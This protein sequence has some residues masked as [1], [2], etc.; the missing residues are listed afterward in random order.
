MEGVDYSGDRPSGLCLYSHGKRFVGRYF[1]PGGTWKH[2]T[3]AEVRAILAS[4]MAIFAL[5]EGD[6]GDALTGFQTG[7]Q[8][9]TQAR[10]HIVRCG[11]PSTLPI[12][13]AVDFDAQPHQFAAIRRYFDGC[14]SVTGRGQVGIYA[15]V[16]V[17]EWAG[18]NDVARWFFQTYA[19]S[20]K[21][22]SRRNH[23]E[24][25]LNRQTVCGAK[26]DLCRNK[27]GDFGQYPRPQQTVGDVP[28]TPPD[29]TASVS[30][31]FSDLL[32]G[33]SGQVAE[34]GAVLD[35]TARQIESLT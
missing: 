25:Y 18:A 20:R 4:G 6:E 32:D 27:A 7:V 1:G 19:W 34:A 17:I 13:Y 15:G 23:V 12:Y 29:T 30:W 14:A 16:D 24:Q 21:R 28:V 26:V 35:A 2:A 5:A 31:E 22:W 9:A 3:A 11:L 8:H 10:A 33:L